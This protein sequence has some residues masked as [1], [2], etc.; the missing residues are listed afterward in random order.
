MLDPADIL[1][2]RQPAFGRRLVERPVRRLAGE[3]DEIPGGI[4]E[5]VE[6]VGLAHRTAP[7]QFGQATCFQLGWR[8]SGLPGM[9]KPM[10]SG[11]TT[12]SWSF[13]TGTAPH[14]SQWMIGI[15]VPQ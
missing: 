3:A 5:G 12:G 6:R 8:S 7:P 4:D 15:G 10:S 9:S 1:V 11:S 13:G 2:D 14:A